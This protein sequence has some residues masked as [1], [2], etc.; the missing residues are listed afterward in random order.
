[1]TI[2]RGKDSFVDESRPNKAF[3]GQAF[4]GL[5]STD[6]A[7]RRRIYLLMS[8]GTVLGRTIVSANLAGKARGAMPAQTITVQ[9]VASS[10]SPNRVTWNNQPGVTGPTASASIPALS[11]GASFSVDV[12]NLVQQIANGANGGKHY[13]WRIT[14]S[15][16]GATY[17]VYGF[18]SSAETSW[19]LDVEVSEAPEQPTML[20]PNGGAV[21]LAKWTVRTDYTDLGGSTD[22]AAMQVQVDANRT[23]PYDFD[24]GQVATTVPELDLATTAYAGL[25]DGAT[26]YW[27][28]RLTD[29]AGFTSDWSDWAQVTRV[30]KPTLTLDNPANGV[31]WDP[32]PTILAHLSSGTV[33][34]YRIWV[35]RA[36]NWADVRYNS[37]RVQGSGASIVHQIPLKQDGRVVFNRDDKQ[38]VVSLQVWDRTDRQSGGPLDVPY[39]EVAQPVLF[40]QDGTVNPPDSLSASLDG[41]DGPGVRLRWSRASAPDRFV[42]IRDN[43]RIASVD[44]VDFSAGTDTWMWVDTSAQPNSTH[45]Y[46]VRA[47]TAVAG[48]DR[49]SKDS[50]L[51]TIRTDLTGVW[52]LSDEHGNVVLEGDGVD[53]LQQKDRRATYSLPYRPDDVDV[54]GA[55]GGIQGTFAGSMVGTE[56]EMTT[57]KATLAAIRADPATPVQL[58]YGTTSIPVLLRNVSVTPA[59]MMLP[60]RNRYEYRVSFEAWQVGDFDTEV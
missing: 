23:A 18:D 42:V 14:T 6:T 30:S 37:G 50:P 15:L 5:R 32:T 19:A 49:E 10:W 22:L 13:G 27:R 56:D 44:A 46:R 16:S 11:A 20:T 43:K 24:S 7:Q 54:V 60:T 47:I 58:A 51:A 33:K 26:T 3:G 41:Y 29:S 12:T 1:M 28:A 4:L 40:D 48:Q 8:P 31:L 17:Q 21:S 39:L 9:A 45:V 34:A 36:D 59:A 35:M 55:L 52:L 25:A 57:A 38:Y 53:E 2:T